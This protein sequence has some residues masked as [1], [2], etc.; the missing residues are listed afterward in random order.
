MV[1]SVCNA[2][3]K[4]ASSFSENIKSYQELTL[5]LTIAKPLKNKTSAKGKAISYKII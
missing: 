4:K 5:A 2:K 3:C 1:D